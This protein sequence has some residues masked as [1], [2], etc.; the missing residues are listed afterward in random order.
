MVI[1]MRN[2]HVSEGKIQANVN[3]SR[4]KEILWRKKLDFIYKI[5]LTS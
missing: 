5:E 1:T 2:Q 4:L 3:N